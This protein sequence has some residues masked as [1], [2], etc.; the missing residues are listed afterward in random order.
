[1]DNI[2]MLNENID[3][4]KRQEDYGDE[5][6]VEYGGQTPNEFC[7]ETIRRI[8]SDLGLEENKWYRSKSNTINIDDVLKYRGYNSSTRRWD[9]IDKGKID[10]R[11]LHDIRDGRL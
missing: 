3:I 9:N 5:Q 11:I 2:E 1:M 10:L 6:M 8:L 4:L 7:R